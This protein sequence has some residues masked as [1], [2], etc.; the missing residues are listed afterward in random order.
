VLVW[1]QTRGLLNVLH[2]V[3]GL[4]YINLSVYLRFGVHLF[5]ETF[6]DDLLAQVNIPS[7][8][9][10]ESFK[11]AFAARH[12][13]LANCWVTMDGLKLFLQQLGNATIQENYYNGWTHDHY[14]TSVFC[15]CLDGT[16]QIAFFN[17]PGSVHDSQVV[18]YGNI[19]GKLEDISCSTGAKCCINLAFG[20]V[21]REYL[22]KLPQD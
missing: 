13:L 18:E 22:Y 14:V 20:Q 21:N 8:E 1:K 3:F 4:I 5:V 15:F 11:E 19:Y 2:L 9:E 12:P 16:I 6:R 7:A 10:M 17:V